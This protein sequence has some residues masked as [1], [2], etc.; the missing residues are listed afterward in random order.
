ML[1]QPRHRKGFTL[2]ELLVVISIIALL[3][4]IL[5]PAL[6]MA[7]E[8]SWAVVCASQMR[9]IGLGFY[10][11]IGDVNGYF[12]PQQNGA[13]D[14]D[15]SWPNLLA[16]NYMGD[17]KE[18][19]DVFECP[20]LDGDSPI[21]RACT[22]TY[23]SQLAKQ[24]QA[25][26]GIFMNGAA[27]IGEV[28]RPAKVILLWE[29]DNWPAINWNSMDRGNYCWITAPLRWGPILKHMS[30]F[31]AATPPFAW[32]PPSGLDNYLCIDGHVEDGTVTNLGYFH[33]LTELDLSVLLDY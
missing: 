9:Q 24:N 30:G 27:N 32:I 3:I 8:A 11:Y 25:N 28:R 14:G 1:I 26:G 31:G 4:S 6:R 15:L 10:T 2:I 7:R 5:L 22:Y 33:T 20:V 12:I 19:D 21:E 23:N 13:F 16:R 18:A 29:H 17:G